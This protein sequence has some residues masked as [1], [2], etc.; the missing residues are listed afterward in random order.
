M[1]FFFVLI[2]QQ[3][4]NMYRVSYK[5]LYFKSFGLHHSGDGTTRKKDSGIWMTGREVKDEKYSK[6]TTNGLFF[7][8]Y[9]YT[10][11]HSIYNMNRDSSK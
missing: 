11:V 3:L 6:Q 1:I 8:L 5:Y 7:S 10:S 2:A 9:V 4:Y